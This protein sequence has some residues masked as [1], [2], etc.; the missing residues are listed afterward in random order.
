MQMKMPHKRFEK[1]L[2]GIPF[3]KTREA[4]KP[5][6]ITGIPGTPPHIIGLMNLHGEII[7]IVDAKTLLNIEILHPS[8]NS[9]FVIVKTGEGPVGIFCDEITEIYEIQRKD[10]E[11]PLHDKL[12]IRNI[13]IL[14]S[15]LNPTP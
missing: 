11:L 14:T 15:E 4:T 7:C 5:P 1:E 13:E 8:K 2:Y 9:R 3:E 10:I 12:C 6:Q